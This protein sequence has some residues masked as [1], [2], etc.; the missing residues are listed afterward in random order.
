MSQIRIYEVRGNFPETT[1]RY[2]ATL[3][4]A[5]KASKE[6]QST[7]VILQDGFPATNRGAAEWLTRHLAFIDDGVQ[8]RVD[9]GDSV[10]RVQQLQ[11]TVME[12]QREVARLKNVV[13]AFDDDDI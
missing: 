13:E 5:Q 10:P 4:E 3:G 8:N 7:M 6:G 12:L 2:A 9:P 1:H 11:D